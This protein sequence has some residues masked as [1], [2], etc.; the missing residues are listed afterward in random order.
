MLVVGR[1]Q[2]DPA[3]RGPCDH[4]AGQSA[5]DLADF[6]AGTQ[7]TLVVQTRPAGD[8]IHY[9]ELQHSKFAYESADPEGT[10]KWMELKSKG[11][12]LSNSTDGLSGLSPVQ[13][14]FLTATATAY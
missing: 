5:G 6:I 11:E 8:I 7:P 4:L 12:L 2:V 3:L 10:N 9:L 13:A 1:P 14:T